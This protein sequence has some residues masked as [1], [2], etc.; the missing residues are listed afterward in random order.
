MVASQKTS[1]ALI[2]KDIGIIKEDVKE[3]KD[4][5]SREYITREHHKRVSDG[6]LAQIKACKKRV[7]FLEKIIFPGIGCV[8]ITILLGILA[9][10]FTGGMAP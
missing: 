6:I 2:Q 4:K 1:I 3:V 10:I 7:G 8:L 5:I 9:F